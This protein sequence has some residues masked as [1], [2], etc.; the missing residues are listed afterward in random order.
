LFTVLGRVPAPDEPEKANTMAHVHY[1]MDLYFP[2]NDRTDQF[3]RDVLRIHAESDAEAVAEA[4]RVN[5]W[6]NS[7]HYR[8]RSIRTASR[9]GD[10]VVFDSLGEADHPRGDEAS[11]GSGAVAVAEGPTA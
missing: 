10:V 7:S 4:H 8:I 1:V 3:R 11:A 9:S 2:Q 5:G 6:R